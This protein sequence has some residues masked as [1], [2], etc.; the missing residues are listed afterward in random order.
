[1]KLEKMGRRPHTP[2]PPLRTVTEIAEILG[3][4]MQTLMWALRD[5]D[6]PKPAMRPNEHGHVVVG[7]NRVWYEPKEV[8]RWYKIRLANEPKVD[9]PGERRVYFRE[10]Y[11]KNRSVAA[12]L[13][14]KENDIPTQSP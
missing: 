12:G 2:R 7:Q 11:R 10:Y 4:T 13:K 1:M 9:A 8:L 6:A 14:E 5:A 3:V